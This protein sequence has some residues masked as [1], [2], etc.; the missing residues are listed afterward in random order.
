[1]SH[2]VKTNLCSR[3]EHSYVYEQ[4]SHILLQRVAELYCCRCI[5]IEFLLPR[6]GNR[7]IIAERLV[8]ATQSSFFLSVCLSVCLSAQMKFSG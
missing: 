3:N 7:W 6:G 5:K 1:M 2:R 4:I 8:F